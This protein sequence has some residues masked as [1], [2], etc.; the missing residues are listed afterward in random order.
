M[1]SDL[2][3]VVAVTMKEGAP[4]DLSFQDGYIRLPRY[5]DWVLILEFREV[6]HSVID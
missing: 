2:H 3:L 6:Y 4:K 1:G 5:K